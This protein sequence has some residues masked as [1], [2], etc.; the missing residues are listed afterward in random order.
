MFDSRRHSIFLVRIWRE[1]SRLAPPGEWRGTLRR[2]NEPQEKFF[3]S[4]EDLWRHLVQL[5][6]AQDDSGGETQAP[7]KGE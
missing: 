1:P 4:A 6:E 5:E 7:V 2:L 3:K